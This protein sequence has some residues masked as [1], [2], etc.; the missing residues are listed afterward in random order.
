MLVKRLDACRYEILSKAMD[1]VPKYASLT[2]RLHN[3]AIWN[4]DSN[5]YIYSTFILFMCYVSRTWP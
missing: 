3:L 5:N 2:F 4:A 1:V